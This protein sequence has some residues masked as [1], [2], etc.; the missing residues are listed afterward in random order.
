MVYGD[1]TTEENIKTITKNDIFKI[2][3]INRYI[4]AFPA[5]AFIKGFG[6]KKGAITLS[7]SHDSHNILV[8]G[9]DDTSISQAVNLIVQ[10]K[11]GLPLHLMLKLFYRYQ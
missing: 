3:V 10:N 6:L 8:V 5:V 11:G 4:N 2:S 9:V 1:C 7:V